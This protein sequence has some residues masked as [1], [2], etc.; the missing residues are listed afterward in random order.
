M[1]LWI[2]KNYTFCNDIVSCTFVGLQKDY[3]AESLN[4]GLVFI[5]SFKANRAQNFNKRKIG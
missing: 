5:V 1:H 4:F 3:T 2:T